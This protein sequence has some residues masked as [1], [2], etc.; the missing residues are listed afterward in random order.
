MSLY[1]NRLRMH[2]ASTP[3]FGK[4]FQRRDTTFRRETR[5]PRT[6]THG[7]LLLLVLLTFGVSLS[8][9]ALSL[10]KHPV[11]AELVSSAAA[12]RP[13]E[14]VELGVLLHMDPGWHTYWKYA[15]AAGA[16]T[17]VA[18]RLPEGFEVGELRWPRPHKYDEQGL[19]V[20]GYADETLL[21]AAVQQP[22]R[23]AVD[24]VAVQA[25]VG[26]LVCREI[27]I[28]GDT[29][30]TLSLPVIEEGPAAANSVLFAR[31]R[32]LLPETWSGSE[33]LQIAHSIS[34]GPQGEEYV[35]LEL[36]I[37][38]GEVVLGDGS[39]DFYPIGGPSLDLFAQRLDPP[40]EPET[41]ASARVDLNIEVFSYDEEKPDVLSGLVVYR[42]TGAPE[43]V[44]K[45]I[46][47]DLA[48]GRSA[49]SLAAFYRAES[50]ARSKAAPLHTYLLFALVGGLILNLMPCVFP[51]IS[52]K[53]L[54]FVAQARE[55]RSR[56]RR[57]GFAFAAGIVATF[58]ALAA[59]VVFLKSGGDQIGWGFQFQA[60]AFVMFLS[61]LVFVLSLSL[62]G[63]VTI[64]LP[65]GHGALGGLADREGL[66]GSFCNGVLATILATPCTAPFLG[67]ALG[68]AFSQDAGI[69]IAIFATTGI[70]MALPYIA[71]AIE[72]GWMRLLPRPGAWME[73]F[74]QLMG[75]LLTA[76]VLWLLWVL[77]KQLGVEAVIWM[78]SFL[79]ALAIA[80]W[81]LGQWLDLRSSPRQRVLAWAAAAT[82]T[83]VA[84]GLFLHPLLSTEMLAVET[85][86]PGAAPSTDVEGKAAKPEW[87]EF[88]PD[89]VESLVAEGRIVFIDFTAEWCWTCKVNKRAVLDSEEVLGK[90]AELDVALVRADWTDG[91]PE[92]TRLLRAF[93]RSGV[94]LYVIFPP[95]R[96]DAAQVLPEVITSGIVI[97]AL[98][99]V[100]RMRSHG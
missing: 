96:I 14:R 79:L 28:P 62:F 57:L 77:G 88:T 75:F 97:D 67:T 22:Q 70:G 52:L 66:S 10:G 37:D 29:L 46:D 98:V 84:Y 31:Y 4:E 5:L 95:G 30:L 80:V 72:P 33:P 11:R 26:W 53:V 49:R 61:A 87:Q 3:E 2:P 12:I 18:W 15:G 47:L 83:A 71:L 58:L 82:L 55:E 76:T 21:S 41:P 89:A 68:F 32:A 24:T 60:P 23:M 35:D 59:V 27:C 6:R 19:I 36:T 90:F 63:V 99:E 54:G 13:G 94:P 86:S 100:S 20:Y 42:P 34:A 38:R 56:A 65:G 64:R 45:R 17:T 93:G 92:I 7:A 91:N 9:E 50:A 44:Y 16:P 69:T 73:R 85:S 25:K 48:S 39:P 40:G 8:A 78:A 51:V 74:K 1:T 43:M 81:I